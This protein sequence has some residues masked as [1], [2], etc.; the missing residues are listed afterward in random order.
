MVLLMFGVNFSG[1]F[2]IGWIMVCVMWNLFFR[3][4]C[5]CSMFISFFI[6]L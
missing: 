6:R 1:L 5:V 2:C 4:V 3:L